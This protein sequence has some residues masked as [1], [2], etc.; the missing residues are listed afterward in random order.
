VILL[1]TLFILAEDYVGVIIEELEE[2]EKRDPISLGALP[3]F[4]C[5]QLLYLFQNLLKL[6]YF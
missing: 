1:Y 6:P 3:I 4:A 2:E 5:Y